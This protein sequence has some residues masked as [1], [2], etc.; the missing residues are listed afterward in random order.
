MEFVFIF[1]PQRKIYIFHNFHKIVKN[2]NQ[3]IGRIR[4]AIAKIFIKAGLRDIDASVLSELIL[5]NRAMSAQEIAEELQSSLS[6]ITGSLHRLMR[7]HLVVRRKEG[8][9]YMYLS[10][11]NVLSIILRLLEDIYQHDIPRVRRLIG[12]EMNRLKDEDAK[13]MKELNDKLEKAQ[14]YLNALIEMIREYSEVV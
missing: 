5:R 9:K 6:G 7:L 11:S 10:E 4:E 1:L 12:E 3:P 2:E 13:L 8:K 14:E